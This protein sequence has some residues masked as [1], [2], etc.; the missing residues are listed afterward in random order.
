MQ[1]TV[2]LKGHALTNQLERASKMV[3]LNDGRAN[4]S[5]G[6]VTIAAPLSTP[7]SDIGRQASRT[8]A[9]VNP[10]KQATQVVNFS[11]TFLSKSLFYLEEYIAKL[12]PYLL[13]CWRF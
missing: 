3:K 11:L 2:N 5:L 6:T 1:E 8:K 7:T 13:E 12:V 10:E 4:P 9:T